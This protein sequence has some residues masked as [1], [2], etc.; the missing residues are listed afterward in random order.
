MRVQPGRVHIEDLP[1]RPGERFNLFDEGQVGGDVSLMAGLFLFPY[2]EFAFLLLREKFLF[3]F[4]HVREEIINFPDIGA[5]RGAAFADALYAE[6]QG[7]GIPVREDKGYDEGDAEEEQEK[8]PDD[9][10]ALQAEADRP[11]P[12]RERGDDPCAALPRQGNGGQMQ[13]PVEP[14]IIQIPSRVAV[15]I[16]SG[17]NGK[18]DRRFEL[19]GICSACETAAHAQQGAAGRFVLQGQHAQQALRLVLGKPVRQAVQ[20]RVYLEAADPVDGSIAAAQRDGKKHDFFPSAR[21]GNQPGKKISP[22][23]IRVI[24]RRLQKFPVERKLPDVELE[25]PVVVKL[26]FVPLREPG[27]APDKEELGIHRFGDSDMTDFQID[28]GAGIPGAGKRAVYRRV[29]ND[30]AGAAVRL[31]E[32]VP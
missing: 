5:V 26:D 20:E 10:V 12:R 27:L 14:H 11:V 6:Q 29:Q 22:G 28:A 15:K 4:L 17:G 2:G 9:G 13:G 23:R 19:P 32:D 25:I 21:Q 7:R 8:A 3:L 18:V 31:Q 30:E 16:R 24:S 1:L